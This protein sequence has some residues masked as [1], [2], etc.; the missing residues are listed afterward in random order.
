MG[1]SAATLTRWFSTR[2][3]PPAVEALMPPDGWLVVT[4]N[5]DCDLDPGKPY[6]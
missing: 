1:E 4:P 2:R 6:V 5:K 3:S